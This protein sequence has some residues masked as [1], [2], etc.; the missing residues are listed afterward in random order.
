MKPLSGSITPA[1]AVAGVQS[2]NDIMVY[3]APATYE[4]G[5]TY[6][7]IID[8]VPDFLFQGIQTGRFRLHR[9]KF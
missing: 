3:T 1:P 4:A 2:L 9:Q 7:F 5:V 6:A 8:M